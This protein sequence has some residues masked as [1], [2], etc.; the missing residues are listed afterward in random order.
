MGISGIPEDPSKRAQYQKEVKEGVKVFEE[1]FKGLQ[2]TNL[3]PKR[4][5]YEK[6]I[7]MSLEALND[8]AKALFNQKMMKMKDRLD[9]DYHQYLQ[10]PSDENRMKVEKDLENLKKEAQ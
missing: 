3:P 4:E 1:S 7:D 8:L 5:E 9:T 10:N 6:S 2:G